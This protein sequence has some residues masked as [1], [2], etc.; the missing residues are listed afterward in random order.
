MRYILGRRLPEPLLIRG[1]QLLDLAYD[2]GD[3]IR[4]RSAAGCCSIYEI[5]C[6]MRVAGYLLRLLSSDSKTRTQLRNRLGFPRQSHK[7]MPN[8]PLLLPLMLHSKFPIPNQSPIPSFKTPRARGCGGRWGIF[9][10]FNM[11]HQPW[12]ETARHGF[13]S[14]NCTLIS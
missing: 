14:R 9:F 1:L 13:P 3:G 7:L 4:I 10:L 11:Y 8:L 12:F 5:G 6:T 2:I